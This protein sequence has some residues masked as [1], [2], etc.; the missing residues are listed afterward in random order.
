MRS[1]SLIERLQQEVEPYRVSCPFPGSPFAQWRSIMFRAHLIDALEPP[2][3]RNMES[4][5]QAFF[6]AFQQ[7]PLRLWELTNTRFVV[8]P[9]Q[10]LQSLLTA[11]QCQL[12]QAFDVD[13]RG[14]I[15]DV[16]PHTSGRFALVRFTRALPRALVYHKWLSLDD[17]DAVLSSLAG[18][19][20]NPQEWAIL[21]GPPGRHDT[22]RS[23]TSVTSLE[24]DRTLIRMHVDLPEEGLL[25][26]NDRFQEGWTA[27]V[28]GRPQAI[29]RVNYIMRGLQLGAGKHVVVMKYE[30]YRGHF[31]LAVGTLLVLIAWSI[32]AIVIRRVRPATP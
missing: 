29:D 21:S 20:L 4:D 15:I 8:G 9:L 32:A 1:N 10:A 5:Y 6:G 7:N 24:H 25:V 17:D 26:V 30:P 14:R 12:V 23:P 2:K 27:T 16:G 3:Q 28:D 18:R 13:A 31:V 19:E 11:G 22:G